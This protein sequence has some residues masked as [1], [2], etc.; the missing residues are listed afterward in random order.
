[1]SGL[2]EPRRKALQRR[3]ARHHAKEKAAAR[4]GERGPSTFL[5]D[6]PIVGELKDCRQL[7]D[8]HW[9]GTDV[10]GTVLEVHGGRMPK[11]FIVDLWRQSFR[12]RSWGTARYGR[13]LVTPKAGL[14][15]APW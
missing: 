11:S 8:D 1:M 3:K 5:D 12:K 7:S 13:I 10:D 15:P 2:A 14:A 6:L 4:E 9:Q